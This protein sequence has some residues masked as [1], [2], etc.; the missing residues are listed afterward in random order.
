MWKFCAKA[1]FTQGF[2][3]FARNPA[4]TVFPQNFL[5]RKLG[6]ITVF[7]AVFAANINPFLTKFPFYAH[8][9]HHWKPEKLKS[10]KA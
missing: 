5:T 7:K 8:W 6:E 4:E 1:Q 10:L 3:Q 2:G 9:K